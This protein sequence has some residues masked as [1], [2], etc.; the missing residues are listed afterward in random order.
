MAITITLDRGGYQEISGLSTDTKPTNCSTGSVFVETD[1]GSVF[2]FDSEGGEWIEQFS[3]QNGGG[4]GLPS[5]SSS[6]IGKVLTVGEGD[7]VQTVI[8]PEQTVTASG[9]NP[10]AL[11]GA[12]VSGFVVGNE[13]VMTVNGTDYDVVASAI[14]GAIV[15]GSAGSLMIGY[16]G[17]DVLFVAIA[18]G[19]YTVSLTV[20]VPKAE[21]KWEAAGGAPTVVNITQTEQN[22]YAADMSYEEIA[23]AYSKG[24]VYFNYDGVNALVW[25]EG[26]TYMAE[27][28]YPSNRDGWKLV[29]YFAEVGAEFVRVSTNTFDLTLST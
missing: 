20:S 21:P 28:L 4:S 10:A 27:W 24:V 8:V 25:R 5:Y 3:L 23:N 17:D 15:F 22:A 19:T 29:Y 18:P 6:D 11:T 2:L 7:P 26:Y 12:D 14:N 1:T 16:M 13:G 9:E